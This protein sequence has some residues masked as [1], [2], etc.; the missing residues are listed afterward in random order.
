MSV[1]LDSQSIA[2]REVV[3]HI[4]SGPAAIKLQRPLGF[5][6]QTCS[7]PCDFN[8]ILQAL[9]SSVT[10]RHVE[11]FSREDLEITEDEWILLVQTL[12]CITGI[13]NLWFSI[14][15][16]PYNVH[17]FQAVSDAVND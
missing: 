2:P 6:D 10:I 13:Q 4:L 12:G 16:A 1:R 14:S 9:R 7:N 8:E 3:D 11:C 15:Y 5:R 17:P